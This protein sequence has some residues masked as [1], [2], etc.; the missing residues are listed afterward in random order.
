MSK[1]QVDSALFLALVRCYKM[2]NSIERIDSEHRKVWIEADRLERT[3][4]KKVAR[5]RTA[6]SPD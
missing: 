4:E 5:A 3:A 1:I 2:H 6:K